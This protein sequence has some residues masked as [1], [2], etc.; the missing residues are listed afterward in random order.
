MLSHDGVDRG[1][2]DTR[3]L[4]IVLPGIFSNELVWNVVCGPVRLRQHSLFEKNNLHFH[5]V[6]LLMCAVVDT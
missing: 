2:E 5:E 4:S 1:I 3:L 6:H